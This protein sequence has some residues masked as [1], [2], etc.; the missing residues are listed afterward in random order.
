VALK[1]PIIP[2][3]LDKSLPWPL[4]G[5]LGLATSNLLYK[6]FTTPFE[7]VQVTWNCAAYS[8]LVKQIKKVSVRIY[9]IEI[10]HTTVGYSQPCILC[11]EYML[12]RQ[13]RSSS[14]AELQNPTKLHCMLNQQLLKTSLNCTF[15]NL[16][17]VRRNYVSVSFYC[18][19]KCDHN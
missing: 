19:H 9:C 13:L 18:I 7:D 11:H 14:K 17:V 2:L 8:D 10:L 16:S 4:P 3:K 12:H 6:D 5:E 15:Q 1:K